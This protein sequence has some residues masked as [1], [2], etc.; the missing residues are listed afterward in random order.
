MQSKFFCQDLD[1]TDV[2]GVCKCLH[3]NGC[4]KLTGNDKIQL[5]RDPE[6]VQTACQQNRVLQEVIQ[7]GELSKVA[8]FADLDKCKLKAEEIRLTEGAASL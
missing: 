5:L 6:E 2:W 1:H 3:D 4:V 7:L 8:K